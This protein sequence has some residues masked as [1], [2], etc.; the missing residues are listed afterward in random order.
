MAIVGEPKSPILQK[1]NNNNKTKKKKTK[2][3]KKKQKKKKKKRSFGY[4]TKV[5]LTTLY[6]RGRKVVRFENGDL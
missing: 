1:N 6:F 3:K 4:V 2:K 5:T